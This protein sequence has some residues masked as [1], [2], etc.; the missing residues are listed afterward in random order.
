MKVKKCGDEYIVVSEDDKVIFKSKD[1]SEAIQHAIE[2]A[3]TKLEEEFF[4]IK[5]PIKI[6][7]GKILEG[8]KKGGE[9]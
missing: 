3:P 6:G 9:K 4:E 7:N 5:E 1:A 8:E 2:R